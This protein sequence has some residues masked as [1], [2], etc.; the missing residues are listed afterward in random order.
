MFLCRAVRFF[1]MTNQKFCTV[2][3]AKRYFLLP[4]LRFCLMR[5]YFGKYLELKESVFNFL[6]CARQVVE[7]RVNLADKIVKASCC[8]HNYL[9]RDFSLK[10]L[11]ISTGEG[12]RASI[13]KKW[14]LVHGNRK[15]AALSN[16]CEAAVKIIS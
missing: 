12:F 13:C 2:L 8:L 1:L 16:I 14:W 15:A 9:M 7:I 4:P 10:F 5:P 3:R 11:Y 6:L